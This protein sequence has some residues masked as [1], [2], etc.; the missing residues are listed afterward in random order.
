V[1]AALPRSD[2]LTSRIDILVT[3]DEVERDGSNARCARVVLLQFLRVLSDVLAELKD[4]NAES[5]SAKNLLRADA[6]NV[7]TRLARPD[8]VGREVFWRRQ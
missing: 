3:A 2:T 8:G 4:S 7:S 1:T 6:A 5:L